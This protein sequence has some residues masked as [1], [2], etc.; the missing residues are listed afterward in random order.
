MNRV[1]GE[2]EALKAV[3]IKIK[4]FGDMAVQCLA[5]AH[6]SFEISASLFDLPVLLQL[7]RTFFFR[8]TLGAAHVSQRSSPNDV[9][10]QKAIIS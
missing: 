4:L 6:R 1:N 8:V 7:P 5:V 3:A 2:V 10:L 9:T